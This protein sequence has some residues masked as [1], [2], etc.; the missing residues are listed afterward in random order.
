MP[1]VRVTPSFDLSHVDTQQHM[2]VRSSVDFNAAVRLAC[3]PPSACPLSAQ[4]L[5]VFG[6]LSLFRPLSIKSVPHTHTH[7]RALVCV[8]Q[9]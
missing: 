5:S 9:G 8:T 2:V 7:Y 3:F 1:Q 6:S 4:S